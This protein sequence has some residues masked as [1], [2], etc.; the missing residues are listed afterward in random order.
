[1]KNAGYRCL[2]GNALTMPAP[3]PHMM[4]LGGYGDTGFDTR[5][6][7]IHVQYISENEP[8]EILFR[9]YLIAHP[10]AAKE[11]AGLKRALWKEFE[12]DRDGYTEAKG[13]F[14]RR[15]TKKAKEERL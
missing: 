7:H 11:Y 9:D 4:F 13:E 1:M 5:V 8:D 10:N 2:D 6:F 3:P 14:V 15:I 12:H